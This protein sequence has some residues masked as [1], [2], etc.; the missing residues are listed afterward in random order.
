MKVDLCIVGAGIIG[1]SLAQEL[2][3][4]DP[5]LKVICVDTDLEGKKSST[6]LNAGG[7]RA[8][9]VQRLN[10]E[11]SKISIEYF[12]RQA[13]QFGFR[14]CGYLWLKTPEQMREAAPLAKQWN[15]WG[16][17]VETWDLSRLKKEL[18]F[19]D[20]TEDL[21]GAYF[22]VRDGLI[23]PNLLKLHY[24]AN[25]QKA[26]VSFVDKRT[27]VNAKYSEAQQSWTLFFKET[28]EL[29]EAKR[30]VNCSGAWANQ[31][32]KILGYKSPGYAVRRQISLFDCR[33]LDFSHGGM[34]IDTSG[35]Y[36]H[37]EATYLLSGYCNKD[38]PQ[39]I[40]FEYGGDEFFQEKI[41][42]P[43]HERSSAF[44]ELKHM[45]GWAGL[46]EVSPDES[47]IVGSTELPGVYESHSYSGHGVMQSYAMARALAEK[48]LKGSTALLDLDAFSS[49]RFKTGK[50]I[51]ETAV[52]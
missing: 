36:F 15:E 23:N 51:L 27:L 28:H 49:E 9:W 33:A 44:E 42:A 31:V 46:Y 10:V 45:T 24:R 19:I 50:L 3:T 48:I 52:I 35:V 14:S 6:E 43:L 41:W 29:V 47:A 12:E 4:L 25:A 8:T 7:V 11:A 30:V 1:S 17:K 20:R 21:E 38:E 18:P 2:V 26:G 32:A 5:S 40:N 39:G 34:A 22:G 16:W 37:P 13:N